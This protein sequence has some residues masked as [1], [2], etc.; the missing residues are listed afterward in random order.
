M[1]KLSAAGLVLCMA[2][3]GG[4]AVAPGQKM[5]TAGLAGGQGDAGSRIQLVPITAQLIAKENAASAP[6]AVAQA[7]LDYHPGKYQIGPGDV[8]FITVWDHPEL[9]AP[10]GSQQQIYANG[11]LVRPDGT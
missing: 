6:P 11:R 9:T 5:D 7:L 10:S 4:C 2:L 1:S 8:L 3:L